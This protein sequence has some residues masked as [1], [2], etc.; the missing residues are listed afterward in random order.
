MSRFAVTFKVFAF[1]LVLLG[2]LTLGAG[3][4]YGQAITGNVVGT[5]VDST[6]AAVVDADLSVV[7]I[8]TGVVVSGKTNETGGYR[9]DNLLPGSYKITVKSGGFRTTTVS[10]EVRLN[11]TSTANVRL[12]P[13]RQHRDRG[14]FGTSAHHR[15][16]DDPAAEH[17]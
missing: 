17:F 10:F 16:H 6:G 4:A 8:A 12:E 13:G 1:A 11:G 15:Y 7:N 5:V 2:L 3:A 9:F 14:S